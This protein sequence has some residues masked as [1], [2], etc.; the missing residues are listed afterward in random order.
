ML[1]RSVHDYACLTARW[2]E[3]CR[4][5][6]LRMRT[7]AKVDGYRVHVVT[8]P[9]LKPTGG[10]YISAGIHG[11]EAGATEGLIA[12]AEDN[13]HRLSRLPVLIFPCLNPWG[14]VH[15][16][17]TDASGTDLNRV[18]HS[19]ASPVIQAAAQ[20]IADRR[21]HVAITLHEDYDGQ[22]TY[23]YEPGKKGRLE[24]WGELLLSTVSNLLPADP[25]DTIDGRRAVGGVIRP[26]LNKL[27]MRYQPEAVYLLLR[28]AERS[29]TLETPSEYDVY[30]R[31]KIHA[32]VLDKVVELAKL[33]ADGAGRQET[34]P[35]RHV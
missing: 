34:A 16:C 9:A 15:N 28:H 32:T 7:L 18:W 12:W 26:R 1:E 25:R 35:S 4:V 23:L 11:D 31:A 3:V 27:A 6:G 33:P 21:F 29:I 20:L 10:L 24:P 17:R 13:A 22:G 8:S 2:R 19:P 14:L 5:S 30:L